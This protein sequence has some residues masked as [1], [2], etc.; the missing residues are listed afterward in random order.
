MQTAG[1]VIEKLPEVSGENE[2]GCW[3]RGGFVLMT[4]GDRSETLAFEV[5]GMERVQLI[6]ELQ[7]GETIMVEWRPNSRKVGDRWFSSLRCFNIMRLADA[8]RKEA[9]NA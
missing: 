4:A 6:R 1:K 3:V 2:H 9:T 7:I 5:N 8:K